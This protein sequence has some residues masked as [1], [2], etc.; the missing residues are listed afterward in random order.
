L[1]VGLRLV[2]D[3]GVG[4]RNQAVYHLN[5]K[6]MSKALLNPVTPELNPTA[7]SYMTR[8]FTGDFAS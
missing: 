6:Y 4:E 1:S 7:Q 2:E 5:P 3:D 8:F